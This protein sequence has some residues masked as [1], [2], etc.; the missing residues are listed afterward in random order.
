MDA[1]YSIFGWIL[2]WPLWLIYRIFGDYGW[3]IILFTLLMQFVMLPLTIRQKKSMAQNTALQPQQENLRKKYANNT[4]KLNEEQQKLFEETGYNMTGGCLVPLLQLPIMFG[5]MDVIYRPLTHLVRLPKD[6]INAAIEIANTAGDAINIKNLQREIQLIS[7]VRSN[8]SIFKDLDPSALD[9]IMNLDINIFGIDSTI[10]PKF[11][12]TLIAMI[13]IL[14]ALT[15]I[16]QMLYNNHITKKSS[17]D[18]R[19]AMGGSGM[20]VMLVG[21]IISLSIGYQFPIGLTIYWTIRNIIT[22]LQEL[23]LNKIMPQEKLVKEAAIQMEEHRKKFLGRQKVERVVTV[24]DDSGKK[25]QKKVSQREYEKK[26]LVEARRRDAEKYGYKL[27][28][29]DQN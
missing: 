28:D 9:K 14:S 19:T 4:T 20:A 6:V 25:S 11:G 16:I 13:P 17:P 2:G 29:N 8:P 23:I 1:I 5:L 27:D 22:F 18:G 3:S 15:S 21:P 24:E 26:K 12:F 7:Q 10:I